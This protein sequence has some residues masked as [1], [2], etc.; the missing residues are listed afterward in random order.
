LAK[1]ILVY[2]DSKTYYDCATV[3][4][5]TPMTVKEMG[6]AVVTRQAFHRSWL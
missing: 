3:Q 1:E 2:R 6:P 4:A 5:G